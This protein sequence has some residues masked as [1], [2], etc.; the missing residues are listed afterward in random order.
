MYQAD[1]IQP[2]EDIE[3]FKDCYQ[4]LQVTTMQFDKTF[5]VLIVAAKLKYIFLQAK[6]LMFPCSIEV[7]S[8]LIDLCTESVLP[9]YLNNNY[10][11]I[12]IYPNITAAIFITISLVSTELAHQ[13]GRVSLGRLILAPHGVVLLHR[14]L[15]EHLEPDHG[16]EQGA[17]EEADA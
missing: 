14:L 12:I 13:V 15:E 6:L 11:T 5:R 8:H 2:S 16:H 1:L 3:R 4:T 17:N 10:P 7:V 9:I